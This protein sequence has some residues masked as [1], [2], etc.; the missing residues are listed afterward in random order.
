[1]RKLAVL[2]NYGAGLAKLL[3]RKR[4]KRFQHGEA[5]RRPDLICHC[6]FY[7]SISRSPF[8]SHPNAPRG[9]LP[10]AAQ[11]WIETGFKNLAEAEVQNTPTPKRQEVAEVSES[12]GVD[13][14]ASRKSSEEAFDTARTQLIAATGVTTGWETTLNTVGRGQMEGYLYFGTGNDLYGQ[15]PPSPDSL[16]AT[17]DFRHMLRTVEFK[18]ETGADRPVI[19]GKDTPE[20]KADIGDSRERILQFL[21]RLDAG[22]R[23]SRVD[24][25]NIGD[26]LSTLNSAQ[27]AELR[28]RLEKDGGP[29]LDALKDDPRLPESHRA[30]FG[31]YLKGNN[32]RSSEDIA[33]LGNNALKHRDFTLFTQAM[34]DASPQAREAFR[35]SLPPDRLKEIFG[36]TEAG[37]DY[38][39]GGPTELRYLE[40]RE[41]RLAED[42][43]KYGE[44]S[45]PNLIKEQT[46]ILPTSRDA[47]KAAIDGISPGQQKLILDGEKISFD[48]RSGRKTSL[49]PEEQRSYEL[50][51]KTKE[52]LTNA[53]N[54][55]EAY[56][57]LDYLD[58]GGTRLISNLAGHR[59][60]LYNS[61]EAAIHNELNNI[62]PADWA[63]GRNDHIYH[64]RTLDMLDTLHASGLS[65]FSPRDGFAT[66]AQILAQ[67]FDRR[68]ETF[69]GS[70]TATEQVLSSIKFEGGKTFPD[71]LSVLRSLSGIDKGSIERYGASPAFKEQLDSAVRAAMR[72]DA[73]K[74]VAERF[75]KDLS[76]GK[77]P[78]LSLKEKVSLFTENRLAMI[79]PDRQRALLN[80]I[81]EEMRKD[82]TLA[83]RL[84]NPGPEDRALVESLR[85]AFPTVRADFFGTAFRPMPMQPK[86]GTINLFDAYVRPLA[87]TGRLSLRVEASLGTH[88][89][90]A[91]TR[92]IA[93]APESERNELLSDRRMQHNFFAYWKQEE[94]D[95][96]MRTARTGDVEP[97]DGLHLA[98]LSGDKAKVEQQLASVNPLLKP[99][100]IE[101]YKGT[102]GDINQQLEQNFKGRELFDLK[103]EVLD[104]PEKARAAFGLSRD[105]YYR[106]R[107]GLFAAFVH[108]F[109]GT[110]LLADNAHHRFATRISESARH[111]AE[112]P[113]AEKDKLFKNAR[114]SLRQFIE[115]K[116]AT[117]DVLVD[118]AITVATLPGTGGTSALLRAALLAAAA[119]PSGKHLLLGDDHSGHY[120]RD[121]ALGAT[122]GLF[123]KLGPAQ[124]SR[125]L[126]A[127]EEVATT[128]STVIA[129]RGLV[130]EANTGAFVTAMKQLVED[131]MRRGGNINGEKL[132]QLARAFAV[133]GSS[134][135][136][137]T[138]IQNEIKRASE[139]TLGKF[140]QRE[141]APNGLSAGTGAGVTQLAEGVLDDR[142]TSE[143]L[144]RALTSFAFAFALGA[145]STAALRSPHL[146]RETGR[147]D[148]ADEIL[149][150]A[151]AS[152][153]A[154]RRD[155]AEFVAKYKIDPQN[156]RDAMPPDLFLE[157]P[158]P[159]RA[160]FP[161]AGKEALESLKKG[162]LTKE[163]DVLI[164]KVKGRDLEFVMEP[165]YARKLDELR[166]LRLSASRAGDSDPQVAAAARAAADTLKTHPLKNAVLPEQVLQILP[167]LPNSSLIKRIEL[168]GTG[169]GTDKEHGRTLADASW[170]N[171]LRIF[172]DTGKHNLRWVLQHENA[173]FLQFKFSSEYSAFSAAGQVD[174]LKESAFFGR[175]YATKNDSEN[176]AVHFGEFFTN[177]NPA[178]F[179]LVTHAAPARAIAAAAML[180]KAISEMPEG[181]RNQIH[182]QLAD[183]IDYVEKQIVPAYRQ[184]LDAAFKSGDI[185]QV[186]THLKFI[187]RLRTADGGRALADLILKTDAQPAMMRDLIRQNLASG[188]PT[189]I[190]SLVDTLTRMDSSPETFALVREL[191][192]NTRI[193][194]EGSIHQA[195]QWFA[196]SHTIEG[197]TALLEF[198]SA[199]GMLDKA[200]MQKILHT[201]PD[202]RMAEFLENPATAALL[203]GKADML[204]AATSSIPKD[205]LPAVVKAAETAGGPLTLDGVSRLYSIAAQLHFKNP[206][207]SAWARAEFDRNIVKLGA[208]FR[209]ELAEGR[210]S[211][212]LDILG[213]AHSP[214]VADRIAFVN[215]VFLRKGEKLDEMI[216]ALALQGLNKEQI[217]QVLRGVR[218]FIDDDAIEAFKRHLQAADE[219]Q[220]MLRAQQ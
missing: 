44:V 198:A 166:Q 140:L 134:E 215:A 112:L 24:L 212:N 66:S 139:S 5:S 68:I 202:L 67:K 61:S 110:G 116:D 81:K 70:R 179:A 69:D 17:Q 185:K 159:G 197:A 125:L 3:Q 100:L 180:R 130:P 122:I 59:G 213:L 73:G 176:Y 45:L 50:Y 121:A 109:S 52:A 208:D 35:Q 93:D 98:I 108:S 77:R 177:G 195:M 55:T 162:E 219:R 209:N 40:T 154:A 170:T 217:E 167:D 13:T 91:F 94:R 131:S 194:P 99:L 124:V 58:G 186:E 206:T 25:Q 78:E 76:D 133:P 164:Y 49:T 106:S 173:H 136:L 89:R 165:E 168:H 88:D 135:L 42:L 33:T 178:D 142:P 72:S 15:R 115:S 41:S 65:L 155:W 92:S 146:L 118:T 102:Y 147:G 143:T 80:D 48:V 181:E 129:G 82:P 63:R 7:R 64:Q 79:D 199:R 19:P 23:P 158:K 8:T 187:E 151:F 114:E 107:D 174:N 148:A 144:S 20:K 120:G 87:E 188:D 90:L 183:R 83:K 31:I 62:S 71:E 27:I 18:R 160:E 113:Q 190:R 163:R 85:E 152:P 10:H 104:I 175:H 74:A 157:P 207:L 54:P 161:I 137:K 211:F 6:Y 26:T 86:D 37:G 169:G 171:T 127:G 28:Q 56:K 95:I 47:L 201:V 150:R 145:G 1:V 46:G 75:L 53:T 123:N 205:H 34:R 156:P 216:P 126:G 218:N 57:W 189:Q 203:K 38:L 220:Q 214:N 14:L 32:E 16:L 2:K 30:A 21:T 103:T 172:A 29:K 138:T 36:K 191:A 182:K 204:L 132:D 193:I 39:H 210:V 111:F 192:D 4:D 184:Q 200:T 60:T 84:L 119:R 153:E 9:R 117:A 105:Q 96:A 11:D 128:A 101:S 97:R 51:I 22:E 196:N 12:V 149:K 141:L 43:M